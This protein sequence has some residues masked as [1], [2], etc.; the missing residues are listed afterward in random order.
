MKII[1]FLKKKTL[2]LS[3]EVFPPTT[4]TYFESVK[5]QP[6]IA[7]LR[8]LYERYMAPAEAPAVIP[9][10]C[11]EYKGALRCCLALYLR[12]KRN[13]CVRINDINQPVF[14]MRLRGD[15]PRI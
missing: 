7:K 14:K 6:E 3:F 12:H 15:I 5:T 8:P 2:S 1:D 11:K 9:G 10:Y 4:E 13:G